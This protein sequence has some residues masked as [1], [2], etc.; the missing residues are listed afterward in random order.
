MCLSCVGTQSSFPCPT[1]FPTSLAV[2]QERNVFH[3]VI[4]KILNTH[5]GKDSRDPSPLPGTT[6]QAAGSRVIPKEERDHAGTG[7]VGTK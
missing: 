2:I 5:E 7:E 4:F 1:I 6:S 3:Q